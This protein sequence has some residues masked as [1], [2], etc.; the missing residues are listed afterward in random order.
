MSDRP[1]LLFQFLF[2]EHFFRSSLK[3]E[4]ASDVQDETGT[5]P[6]RRTLTAF[7][8]RRFSRFSNRRW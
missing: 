3:E 6:S 4:D 5:P 1:D 7:L 8:S 2:R